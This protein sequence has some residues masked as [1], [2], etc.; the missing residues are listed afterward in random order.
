MTYLDKAQ[1]GTHF[2][3]GDLVLP[4]TSRMPKICVMCMHIAFSSILDSRLNRPFLP[5]VTTPKKVIFDSEACQRSLE[6]HSEPVGE[7]IAFW[8][9]SRLLIELLQMTTAG[10]WASVLTRS[11]IVG[12]FTYLRLSF[13]LITIAQDLGTL[14]RAMVPS[15]HFS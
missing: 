10:T 15:L 12:I 13:I 2:F 1:M 7:V 5:V 11:H 3:T 8:R 6:A 9:L 4:C 14:S